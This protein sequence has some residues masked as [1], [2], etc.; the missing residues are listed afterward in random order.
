VEEKLY[1]MYTSQEQ[2]ALGN[3]WFRQVAKQLAGEQSFPKGCQFS[4]RWLGNFKKRY[5][6]GTGNL[7]RLE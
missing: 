4:E 6:I 5:N 7:Y 3:Q 2:A 1:E